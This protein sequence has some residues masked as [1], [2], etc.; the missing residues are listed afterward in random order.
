MRTEYSKIRRLERKT[1][2]KR[3]EKTCCL[4]FRNLNLPPKQL[5]QTSMVKTMHK[6]ECSVDFPIWLPCDT[7]CIAYNNLIH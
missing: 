1:L 5:N 7:L 6:G 2:I 4:D 3:E